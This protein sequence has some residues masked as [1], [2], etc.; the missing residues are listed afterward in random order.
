[1]APLA[2]SRLPIVRGSQ[3]RGLSP[4]VSLLVSDGRNLELHCSNLTEWKTVCR[5]IPQV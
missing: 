4:S 1:V 2:A 5:W 3:Q